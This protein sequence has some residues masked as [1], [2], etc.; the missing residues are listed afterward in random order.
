MHTLFIDA[1]IHVYFIYECIHL[2]Y[3]LGWDMHLCILYLWMHSSSY[4]AFLAQTCI[5]VYFIYGCIHP[6]ILYLWIHLY[7]ILGWDMHLCI[8]IYGCIHLY[9]ILG[10]DMHLCIIYLWLKLMELGKVN[11]PD[12]FFI[13]D[14]RDMGELDYSRELHMLTSTHG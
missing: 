4:T 11:I 13:S 9:H 7:Y 14:P 1:S 10:W 6:C 8:I 2:Y 12:H 5:Y 3:I